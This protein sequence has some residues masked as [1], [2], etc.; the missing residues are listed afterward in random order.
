MML[1]SGKGVTRL[2]LVGGHERMNLDAAVRAWR[3]VR[4]TYYDS[5]D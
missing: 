1:R 5:L 2:G 3:R 4:E